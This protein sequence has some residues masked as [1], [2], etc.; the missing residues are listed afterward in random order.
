MKRGKTG[1]W[2][3]ACPVCG[4][5]GVVT[6]PDNNPENERT[7]WGYDALDR[8]TEEVRIANAIIDAGMPRELRDALRAHYDPARGRIIDWC[9]ATRRHEGEGI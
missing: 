2:P 3:C 9:D 4:C 8:L 1:K 5:P 7:V 6:R